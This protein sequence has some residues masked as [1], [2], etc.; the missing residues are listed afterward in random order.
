MG[1]RRQEQTAYT[2]LCEGY[3]SVEQP[4]KNKVQRPRSVFPSLF[5]SFVRVKK[6]VL[7]EGQ[8]GIKGVNARSPKLLI[9]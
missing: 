7:G 2:V 1:E 3:F 5:L 8:R 6:F 4:R 9:L